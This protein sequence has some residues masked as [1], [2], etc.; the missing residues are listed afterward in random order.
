MKNDESKALKEVW[1]LK[2][3]A[4]REVERMDLR[5]ALKERIKKSSDTAAILGFNTKTI[6]E[7]GNFH[8]LCA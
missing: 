1:E 2:E 6:K 5:D 8:F 3:K 7:Y 4:Y